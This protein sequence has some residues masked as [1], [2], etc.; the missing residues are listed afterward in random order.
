[1]YYAVDI[2]DRSV[3]SYSDN[4]SAL[5]CDEFMSKMDESCWLDFAK[6]LLI[7]SRLQRNKNL[8]RVKRQGLWDGQYP[9][10]YT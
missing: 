10:K 5:E 7:Q 8:S 2:C 1:M 4:S 3:S 6:W 9:S